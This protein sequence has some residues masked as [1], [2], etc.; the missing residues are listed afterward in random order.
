MDKSYSV[1]ENS[2]GVPNP[3]LCPLPPKDPIAT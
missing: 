3:K 2:F 1:L